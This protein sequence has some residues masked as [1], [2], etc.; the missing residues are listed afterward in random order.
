MSKVGIYTFQEQLLVIYF[1]YVCH[2]CFRF[3]KWTGEEGEHTT[4]YDIND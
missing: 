4:K 3:E 1:N 2:Q